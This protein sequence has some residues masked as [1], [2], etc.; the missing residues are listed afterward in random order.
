MPSRRAVL[1]TTA[2]AIATTGGCLYDHPDPT[3]TSNPNCDHASVT[4]LRID[5]RGTPPNEEQ[6][7]I[8]EVTV[9]ELPAPALIVEVQV[10]DGSEQLRRSILE[11]G[12]QR[13]EFGPY[14][15]LDGITPRFA[16]C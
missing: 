11:S 1:A 12:V 4:D 10:C 15:C 7:A 3:P 9:D 2:A 16:G 6:Y 8:V 14:D 13:F 5:R